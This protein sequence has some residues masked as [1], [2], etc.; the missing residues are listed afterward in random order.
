MRLKCSKCTYTIYKSNSTFKT[1]LKFL[2]LL[3]L[4]SYFLGAGLKI[5]QVCVWFEFLCYKMYNLNII[6]LKLI[7]HSK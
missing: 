3:D 2:F 5:C 6:Y 1:I 7:D 4:T